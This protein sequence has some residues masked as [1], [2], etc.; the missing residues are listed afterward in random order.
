MT[1][2]YD[3]SKM[4][5]LQK[6]AHK[7][8]LMLT[9]YVFKAIHD[10]VVEAKFLRHKPSVRVNNVLHWRKSVLNVSLQK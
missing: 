8:G 9:K 6:S 3:I 4:N 5:Y 1:V 10:S 2:D 7:L